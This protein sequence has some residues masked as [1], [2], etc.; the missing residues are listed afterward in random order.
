MKGEFAFK[1]TFQIKVL[2]IDCLFLFCVSNMCVLFQLAIDPPL[3]K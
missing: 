3:S 2:K 1:G